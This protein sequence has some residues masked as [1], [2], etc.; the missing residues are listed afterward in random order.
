MSR[1]LHET[2]ARPP[3]RG[4]VE[5]AVVN[6]HPRMYLPPPLRADAPEPR[7]LVGVRQRVAPWRVA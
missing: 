3:R 6:G 2:L 5:V 1:V 4:D 7:L